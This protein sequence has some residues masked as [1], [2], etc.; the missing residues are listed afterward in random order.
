MPSSKSKNPKGHHSTQH[1]LNISLCTGGDFDWNYLL[2]N[3]LSPAY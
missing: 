3:N 2:T 1:R